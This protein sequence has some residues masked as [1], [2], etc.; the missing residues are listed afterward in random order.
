MT[1]AGRMTIRATNVI[2]NNGPHTPDEQLLSVKDKSDNS[3]PSKKL[4]LSLKGQKLLGTIN[5][6]VEGKSSVCSV[7]PIYFRS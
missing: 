6:S 3:P 2:E 4:R 5:H 7:M 1:C